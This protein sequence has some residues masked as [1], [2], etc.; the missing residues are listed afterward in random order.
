MDLRLKKHGQIMVLVAVI[1]TKIPLCYVIIKRKR[2]WWWWWRTTSR[3]A[4]FL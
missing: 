3:N 1:A 2:T 4:G